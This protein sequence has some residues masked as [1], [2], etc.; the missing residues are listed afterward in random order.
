MN[1]HTKPDYGSSAYDYNFDF[2][3]DLELNLYDYLLLGF[4][5]VAVFPFVLLARFT[6]GTYQRIFWKMR[7]KQGNQAFK[8]PLKTH[9][10]LMSKFFLIV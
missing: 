7:D 8:P 2:N 10:S 6:K 4:Y 9:V 5:L 3:F 1:K